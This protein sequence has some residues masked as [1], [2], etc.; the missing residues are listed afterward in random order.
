MI[1]IDKTSDMSVFEINTDEGSVEV[2]YSDIGGW[3]EST[4]ETVAL[5]LTDT[6]DE[7]M[8]TVK[9]EDKTYQ[10]NVCE[11]IHLYFALD[12]YYK[13]SG[14]CEGINEV[15]MLKFEKVDD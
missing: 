2:K 4:K 11:M 14:L 1:Y 3:T 8:H 6:S 7:L 12:Y 13:H 10:F 15:K 5:T 9:T